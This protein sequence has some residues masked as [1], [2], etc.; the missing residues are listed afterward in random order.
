M[1]RSE[2]NLRV[3]KMVKLY[4]HIVRRSMNKWKRIFIKRLDKVTKRVQHKRSGCNKSERRGSLVKIKNE[5][6]ESV[7]HG[8]S[9]HT[10]PRVEKNGIVHLRG[11]SGD[12]SRQI[13]YGTWETLA[14]RKDL[15]YK[16]TKWIRVGRES[17]ET[18]VPMMI[19]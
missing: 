5:M 18:I 2:D 13:Q 8:R 17:D 4:S 9:Q 10:K 7:F 1:K 14:Y 6:D 11:I 3:I 15:S 19:V 12:M 16:E